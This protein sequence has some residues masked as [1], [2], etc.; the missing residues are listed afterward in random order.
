[1]KNN[2]PA[3]VLSI[4][5]SDCSG[6]AGIQADIKTIS[7]IGCY[8]TTAITAITVQNTLG[9]QDI[10]YLP[11][12]M[13]SE[14]IK[15]V[16]DDIQPECIKIGMIGIVDAAL[17]IA[18]TLEKYTFKHLVIDTIISSSSGTKLLDDKAFNIMQ[19]R[20]FP[21]ATLITPN[22]CEAKI[23]Y[24]TTLNNI[25]LMKEAAEKMA[26]KYRCSILVKGGHCDGEEKC[27]VFYDISNGETKLFTKKKIDS[28]NLHGTGC[29]LASA[30]AAYLAKGM[31]MSEAIGFAKEYVTQG[32]K[33][34]QN[35]QIGNGNGPLWH[36]LIK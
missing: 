11:G 34:A 28:R 4:A 10:H 6:G 33:K 8:A 35:M 27:D 1:M 20:L 29:T 32:I 21:M 15:A 3:K 14:Q 31:N 24:P 9:I 26:L 16:M 2:T 30:I 23:L 13:I 7:A 25:E 19:E 18:N 17:A 22:L 12:K 5:G 36:F